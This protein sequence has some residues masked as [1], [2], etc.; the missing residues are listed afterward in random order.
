MPLI[1][2][3]WLLLS[4]GIFALFSVS[5]HESFTTT[6]SLINKGKL[7]WDPSNYFY[8]FKQLHNLV[9][10]FW[11]WFIVY[12]FPLKAFKSNR[13]LTLL[14]ILILLFQL[15]VFTPLGTSLN[16]ARWWLDLPGLPS[17]QPSEF[18][19]VWYV[20]FLAWWFVR[21]RHLLN[22]FDIMK[23]YFI[24]HIIIFFA[25]LLIPD[26]GSV[27]VMAFTGLI[28]CWYAGVSHENILKMLGIWAVLGMTSL[29]GLFSFNN[30]FC[31][32]PWSSNWVQWSWTKENPKPW[33]CKLTYITKRISVFW[34]SDLD[35]DDKGTNRQNAQALIAIGGGW[36]FGKG[37]WKWLQKFGQIPEAQ[38]DFIFAAFAEE[39]GFLGTLI[40]L[41]LYAALAWYTIIKIPEQKDEYFKIISVW[42]ISLI[43]VQM[44]V[45]IGVNT[46]LI[47]NTWLT[48]PFISYGGTALMTNIIMVIL[49]YK[50]L[51]KNA[52]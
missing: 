49:L 19:K 33:Y 26:I 40:L 37:Y 42:L 2:I 23:K 32:P 24:V 25:F 47:P 52:E 21:K 29:I 1:I 43:M 11:V 30:T 15:L 41:G 5:I 36:T 7:E 17:I 27:L 48:L 44:F 18:F 8:F 28:M 35:K 10:A 9:W 4:Y 38:S 46:R 3:T 14:S 13:F 31:I 51:Y 34:N 6:L 16:G 22:S 39:S 12:I 20:I 45:N 50:I